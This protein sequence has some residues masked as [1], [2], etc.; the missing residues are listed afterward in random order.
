MEYLVICCRQIQFRVSALHHGSAYRSIWLCLWTSKG[1]SAETNKRRLPPQQLGFLQRPLFPPGSA[2]R[3]AS[4]DQGYS[5]PWYH[6][7]FKDSS[8]TRNP[9]GAGVCCGKYSIPV[10]FQCFNGDSAS[11]WMARVCKA[12]RKWTCKR[13]QQLSTLCFYS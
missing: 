6:I 12:M 2:E 7:V 4:H 1:V 5:S 8:G 9:I 3:F 11:N 10:D 13:N